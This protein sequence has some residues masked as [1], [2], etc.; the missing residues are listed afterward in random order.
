MQLLVSV[1]DAVEAEIVCRYPIDRLDLKE[2]RWGSLGATS[3]DIW[4]TVVSQWHAQIGVSIALGELSDSPDPTAVPHQTESIKVG[5]AGCSGLPDWP[6]RL[7]MLYATAPKSVSRV[8]VFYADQQLARC[9]LFEDLLEVAADLQCATILV[10][11]FGKT[12]GSVFG[13][14]TETQLIQM[15]RAAHTIDCQFALAGSL[16]QHDLPIIKNVRPDIVAVRGA[17]CHHDRSGHICER[18]LSTFVT[19]F[20]ESRSIAA[21]G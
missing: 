20:E 16:Q 15:R 4:Q 11:T 3:P 12:S 18:R 7:R 10:D 19:A 9:P 14:L 1:R 13:H 6:E 5:L 21:E 8:A 2:P 17:V